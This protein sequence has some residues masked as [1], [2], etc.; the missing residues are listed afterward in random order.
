MPRKQLRRLIGTLAATAA[1]L[2]LM[3]AAAA[4]P[5]RAD[6][7]DLARALIAVGAIAL[8]AKV[9]GDSKRRAPAVPNRGLLPADCA[10]EF[11]QGRDRTRVYSRP[12]LDRYGF[13][14]LPAS[15][16]S[17]VRVQGRTIPVYGDRCLR[18]AGFRAE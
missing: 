18:R 7:R 8:I 4:V 10:I 6:N 3:T 9:A 13:W 12:C 16:E 5:A 14:D 11:D 15:C 1:A 2:G 17:S